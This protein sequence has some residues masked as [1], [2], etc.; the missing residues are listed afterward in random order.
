[1]HLKKLAYFKNYFPLQANMT[2]CILA[3]DS[4]ASIVCLV[5]NCILQCVLNEWLFYVE[6]DQSDD[7]VDDDEDPNEDSDIV[8]DGETSG[9]E[10]VDETRRE[11]I[12]HT[13]NMVLQ[14]PINP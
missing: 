8:I 14:S 12:P 3:L 13:P 1:M 5:N 2:C 11:T 9:D 7:E 10:D 6:N 4:K